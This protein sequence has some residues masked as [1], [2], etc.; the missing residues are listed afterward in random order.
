MG[1]RRPV[2]VYLMVTEE[3]IEDSLLATLS[4]KKD[5]A[6]A[7]L[8]PESTVREMA[9]VGSVEEMKR[10]LEV[11]LGKPPRAA[12]DESGRRRL[13]AEHV[14]RRARIESAG[15]EL[16]GAAFGFIG[17]LLGAD[18]RPRRIRLS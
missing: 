11:L 14:E 10:R 5:M 16:L 2:Q 7:V 17:E 4:M 15:G 8:D 3:T 13:E 18:T 6:L 12:E 1:Q 9:M